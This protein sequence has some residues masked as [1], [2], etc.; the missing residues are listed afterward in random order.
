M[1][2]GCPAKAV[3]E[4]RGDEPPAAFSLGGEFLL[5]AFETFREGLDLFVG[6]LAFGALLFAELDAWGAGA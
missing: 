5:V 4:D 3:V 6:E 1:Q 2:L